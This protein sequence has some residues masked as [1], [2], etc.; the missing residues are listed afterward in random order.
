[1]HISLI[2]AAA[3]NHV[4]GRENQLP[5]RLPSDLKYFKAMTLGKPVLMGRKTFE[6]IGRPLPGRPNIVITRNADWQVPAAWR[7]QIRVA[8]SIDAALAIAGELL[9]ESGGDEAVVIGGA[10]IYRAALQYCDRIYLTRVHVAIDGDAFFSVP[11]D[12]TWQ[13]VSE[14]VVSADD[15]N[16]YAHTFMIFERVTKS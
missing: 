15:A 5:W 9:A 6:S 3:E 8:D 16:A 7:D 12:G 10:E 13:S 2:V 1:M 14:A 4:I 11:D